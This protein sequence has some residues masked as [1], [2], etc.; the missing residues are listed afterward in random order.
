MT[1]LL[2]AEVT[3]VLGGFANIEL[4]EDQEDVVAGLPGLVAR[5]PDDPYRRV[6]GTADFLRR[7]VRRPGFRLLK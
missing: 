3:D 1:A 6:F 2:T 4:R 5:V 7:W